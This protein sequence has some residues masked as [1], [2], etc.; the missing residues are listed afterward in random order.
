[1]KT[2]RDLSPKFKSMNEK[3]TTVT[4]ATKIL[5]FFYYKSSVCSPQL[6]IGKLPFSNC[7]TECCLSQKTDPER[8]L[9]CDAV[10]MLHYESL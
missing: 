5:V 9:L 6:P 7:H 1:M 4:P 3:T 8:S 10:S 2:V